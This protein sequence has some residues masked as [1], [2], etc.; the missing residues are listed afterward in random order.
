MVKAHTFM[1]RV[2][3]I[4]LYKRIILDHSTICYPFSGD[5]ERI[6]WGCLACVVVLMVPLRGFTCGN[7]AGQEVSDST[8]LTA[9]QR[10]VVCCGC[11]F[12]ANRAIEPY[13]VQCYSANC[14]PIGYGITV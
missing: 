8:P 9:S 7:S 5:P 12:G 2:R 10:Q 11:E 3:E 4:Q 1:V 14:L 13:V 6:A